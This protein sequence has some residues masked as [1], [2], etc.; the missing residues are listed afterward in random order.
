MSTVE[1][2]MI[3]AEGRVARLGD[4]IPVVFP[5]GKIPP[6]QAR[7][8]FL[9]I[10]HARLISA[11]I[12]GGAFRTRVTDSS[13]TDTHVEYVERNKEDQDHGEEPEI[14]VR[15]PAHWDEPSHSWRVAEIG[16]YP[17]WRF[18]LGWHI[19]SRGDS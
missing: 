11:F 14:A 12:A 3:D 6:S 7:G 4:E 19:F 8:A 18:G 5:G 10:P 2:Q 1:F 17:A 16:L 15:W 9:G 13:G